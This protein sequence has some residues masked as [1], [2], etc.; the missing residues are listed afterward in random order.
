MQHVC[1][2]VFVSTFQDQY[3][4]AAGEG[5]DGKVVV[6]VE[7]PG[8]I[9]VPLFENGDKSLSY[10]LTNGETLI[11]VSVCLYTLY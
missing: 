8:D 5:I 2:C 4:N 11:T 3:D 9:V 10:S 6:T 1:I 7:G